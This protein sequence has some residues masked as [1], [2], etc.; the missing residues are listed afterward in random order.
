MFFT[1]C[2][3]LKGVLLPRYDHLLLTTLLLGL[4]IIWDENNFIFINMMEVAF[5]ISSSNCFFFFFFPLVH[6][7]SSGCFGKATI[8][9]W[10]FLPSG[11]IELCDKRQHFSI[12]KIN[13]W[14]TIMPYTFLYDL[15]TSYAQEILLLFLV[16]LIFWYLFS[17]SSWQVDLQTIWV[18]S[19][20]EC[21]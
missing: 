11:G 15:A 13:K 16:E 1:Y 3:R 10:L 20:S 9:I 5:S 21:S 19:R 18:P 14:Q 4:G 7:W 8:R 17:F 2:L 6:G 12:G